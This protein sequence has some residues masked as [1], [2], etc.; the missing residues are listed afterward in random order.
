MNGRGLDAFGVE[1]ARTYRAAVYAPAADEL[2]CPCKKKIIPRQ[3]APSDGATVPGER[4]NLDVAADTDVPIL[5][6]ACRRE[7]CHRLLVVPSRVLATGQFAA[8][9]SVLVRLDA[10]DGTT[11]ALAPPNVYDRVGVAP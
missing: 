5:G 3:Y 9:V 2:R 10:D 4:T 8:W 6:A 1:P 11:V 7:D